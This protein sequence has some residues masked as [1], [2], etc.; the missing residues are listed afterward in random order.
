[1]TNVDVE[2]WIE[3]MLASLYSYFVHSIKQHL[4]FVKLVEVMQSKG[5]KILKNVII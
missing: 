4:E 2:L 1:M 5:L 3:A